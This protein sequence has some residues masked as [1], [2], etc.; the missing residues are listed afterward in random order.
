MSRWEQW[1]RAL[2]RKENRFTWGAVAGMSLT[3]AA[4]LAGLL[5][6]IPVMPPGLHPVFLCLATMAGLACYHLAVCLLASLFALVRLPLPRLFLSS[7]ICFCGG[8]FLGWANYD[9]TW[10]G[11]AAVAVIYAQIAIAGGTMVTMLVSRP[12]KLAAVICGV[13]AAIAAAGAAVW[14]YGPG[15]HTYPPASP[16]SAQDVPAPLD[17]DNPGLPGNYEVRTFTYGSGSDRFRKEFAD[18]ADMISPTVDASAFLKEWE[19]PRRWFWGFGPEALP[20]NGRVWVP[21]G[22]GPFPLALIVHGNHN[23]E[24]FS[25]EG[26]A[27]LGELLASRGIIAVSVDENF[28][29]YSVWS[30]SVDPDMTIRAWVL[31][32]HLEWIMQM[33][34][35]AGNAFTGKVDPE[36]VA[37]IGHSR[38][39][40]AAA[41]AASFNEFFHDAKEIPLP[42]DSKYRIRSVAAIAP[43]DRMIDREA[44]WL[45]NVNYLVL[46]GSMDGDVNVY[47]GSRQYHR[48]RWSGNEPY[49]KT[50]LYIQG[51]NHGQFNTRWGDADISSPLHLLMNRKDMLSG[52]AQ[53]TVAKVFVS[54]FLETTLNGNRD[55]MPVFQDY[56]HALPWLPDTSYVQQYEDSGFVPVARFEEDHDKTTAAVRGGVITADGFKEWKEQ[57]VKDREGGSLMNDA[58]Y[59]AWDGKNEAVYVID[60]T[61]WQPDNGTGLAGRAAERQE[62]GRNSRLNRQDNAGSDAVWL[63]FDL[64]NAALEPEQRHQTPPAVGLEIDTLDGGTVRIAPDQIRPVP[65]VIHTRFTK[66]VFFEKA[67]RKGNLGKSA[68]PVMQTFLVPLA[69][70]ETG[71]LSWENRP[72]RLRV[73]FPQG[74]PGSILLD[75]IG[76]Y[77]DGLLSVDGE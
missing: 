20:L 75:N 27:Y 30:G 46:Q 56:R 3:A 31:L 70:G 53:R 12:P 48:I 40:Q 59:L 66:S 65:R 35:T 72:V 76:F 10:Q 8:T 54:A 16:L 1:A 13:A 57:D 14:L 5:Q 43:I 47:Y 28:L 77:P 29:N 24:F 51:A 15:A 71:S 58:V 44:V 4:V 63:A 19:E 49:F 23:M 38:G 11:A 21:A 39:G 61:G 69:S 41:L 45:R 67:V 18:D 73:V 26:Y 60:L 52:E 7:L 6:G 68:E 36:R 74:T 9:I 22:E 17:A 62:I 33:N 34:E 2:A 55:Y 32:K 50:S 25:D 37:L 64:A 42:D